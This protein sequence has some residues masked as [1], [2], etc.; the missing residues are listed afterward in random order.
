MD[1]FG[2]WC[3]HGERKAIVVHPIH[4]SPG[5]DATAGVRL[6][7]ITVKVYL[8]AVGALID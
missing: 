1:R 7:L 2:G 3:I 4:V 8:S 5:H 6:S